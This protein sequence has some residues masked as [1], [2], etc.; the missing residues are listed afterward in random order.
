MPLPMRHDT[1]PTE[2]T[3]QQLVHWYCVNRERTRKLFDLIEPEA[4]YERPIAL[5]NPIVFYEGHLPA[6]A[7]NTLVKGALSAE[8]VDAQLEVLFERG[9][10]P[11][12]EGALKGAP[13]SWP[14]RPEVQAYALAADALI[15]E[16]L[17][18]ASLENDGI[19]TLRGGEAVLTILEHEL[20]H[21]ETLLYMLH[22]LPHSQKRITPPL[23]ARTPPQTSGWRGEEM[24]D[25]D[26]GS[27]TLGKARDSTFGWDNEFGELHVEVPEFSIGRWNVTNA[28]FHEFVSAGGYQ[29]RDLW[30]PEA[31]GSIS[32]SDLHHPH[33]WV[34]QGGHYLWRGMFEWIRLPGRWPA[35]VTHA[36]AEAYARWRGA[37]LLTEPEYQRAAYGTPSGEVRL[38]P[39]GSGAHG[40]QHGWFNFAGWD[41]CEV[42][43]HPAGA[44]AWGVED[45]VG[46][47]WEWTST[48]FGPLPGF[49]PMPSY[50]RYSADFFDEAHYVL[51]GASPITPVELIRSTFR[52]WF[53]PHYP[54][55]FASFRIAR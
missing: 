39:W 6:F 46:N 11:E 7:V 5:R 55:V 27:A 3:R 26:A 47:G 36:E 24:I 1:F 45:L 43:T 32:K 12:D 44:S 30:S 51:K 19:P 37:R 23:N 50:P 16:A 22:N 15:E 10:D 38:H 18:H 28:E 52:N 25:I 29:R 33:F 4:Y 21:Q 53:R 42:G 49:E 35:W 31:W 2:I 13:N 40:P 14:A 54:Y 41:P 20:M 9:I 8:G 48:L 34:E 17:L